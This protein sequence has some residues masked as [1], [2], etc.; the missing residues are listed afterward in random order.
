M[1]NV[2]SQSDCTMQPPASCPAWQKPWERSA[3]CKHRQHAVKACAIY[4]SKSKLPHHAATLP[5][6]Q[7]S[8]NFGTLKQ[9]A[10]THVT[11]T[12]SSSAQARIAPGCWKAARTSSPSYTR[13]E[14]A[15]RFRLRSCTCSRQQ[16]RHAQDEP[17]QSH[18][19]RLRSLSVQLFACSRYA[20]QQAQAM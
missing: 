18:S 7:L 19:S 14:N 10:A 12:G 13:P 15:H 16:S 6:T 5:A 17:I 8:H 11:Q 1:R 20:S 9:T 4:F 2:A 3:S